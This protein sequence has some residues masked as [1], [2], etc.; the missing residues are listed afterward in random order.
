MCRTT[1]CTKHSHVHVSDHHI[2]CIFR[3][4]K[5]V[6]LCFCNAY[7][8][9]WRFLLI[10][11]LY[12][13]L[14]KAQRNIHCLCSIYTATQHLIKQFSKTIS[15]LT[16]LFREVVKYY[17]ADFVFGY[18][19]NPQLFFGKN[20]V[21]KGGEGYPPYGQNPQSSIWPPPL[22]MFSIDTLAVIEEMVHI[23]LCKKLTW[24]SFAIL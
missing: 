13:T 20:F 22:F 23:N 5:Y 2:S 11:V 8:S 12:N 3:N 15:L 7:F 16:K 9:F 4:T 21:R 19:P 24:S 17:F 1:L 18:P 10:H 6:F 14:Y